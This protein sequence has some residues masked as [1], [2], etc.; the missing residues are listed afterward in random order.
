VKWRSA[1]LSLADYYVGVLGLT[2]AQGGHVLCGN[3]NLPLSTR[4]GDTVAREGE[5]WRKIIPETAKKSAF[6]GARIPL[7]AAE[8]LHCLK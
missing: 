4:S 8:L 6:L 5:I 7:P 2:R 3:R 1:A